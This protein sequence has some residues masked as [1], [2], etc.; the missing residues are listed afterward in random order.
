METLRINA[1]SSPRNISTAFMYAFAQRPDTQVVDEPLYA[2]YLS[3]TDSKAT[4]PGRHEILNS[5]SADGNEVVQNVLL[6]PSS[7]PIVLCK[8]M[9]HHLIKLDRSFLQDMEQSIEVDLSG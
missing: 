9:T 4:H 6:G 2:H 5:Q 8:Q 1:W 7:K 3:Q